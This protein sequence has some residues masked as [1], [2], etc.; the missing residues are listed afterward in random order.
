M[1]IIITQSPPP[2]SS[3]SLSF[4]LPRSE[5]IRCAF[6]KRQPG[7]WTRPREGK[8]TRREGHAS[9]MVSLTSFEWQ[10]SGWPSSTLMLCS[11]QLLSIITLSRR[12][13]GLLLIL[14][15]LR[16]MAPGLRV[17]AATRVST[18]DAPLFRAAP[19]GS[20]RSYPGT[21]QIRKQSQIHSHWSFPG[22]RKKYRLRGGNLFGSE[23]SAELGSRSARETRKSYWIQFDFALHCRG[24]QKKKRNTTFL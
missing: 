21:G 5:S 20:V 22:A 11:T 6:A 7:I 14:R 2:L 13:L 24:N 4:P 19:L 8:K 17:S 12:H 18:R 23:L 9:N 15:R 10:L 3:C 16:K 1:L